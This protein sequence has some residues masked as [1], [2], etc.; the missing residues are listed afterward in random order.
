M[1]SFL[2]LLLF[3]VGCAALAVASCRRL[4]PETTGT[5]GLLARAVVGLSLVVVC[6]EAAGVL[7]G[8]VPWVLGAV[9]AALLLAAW[10]LDPGRPLPVVS[11]PDP[12]G[13]S[14]WVAVAA[15]AA[16]LIA[17]SGPIVESL[18][19]GIYRQDSLWYHLTLASGFVQ[20]GQIGGLQI[21]D[22][23]KLAAWFYPQNAE[24]FHGLGMLALGD[25][26]ASPFLNL[27][28]ASLTLLAGWCIGRRLG[29]PGTGIAATA[30]ILVTPMMLTQAGNAPN[31]AAG[32]ALVAAAI[33]M[34][35]AAN[36]DNSLSLIHI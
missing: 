5:T 32:L 22:P 27:L 1:I 3:L 34:L 23:L 16:V 20:D 15:C 11:R 17:W 14:V 33:A 21:T 30:L 24:I 29:R 10:R 13:S 31:D 26:F 12:S 4:A 18:D 35:L 8:F 2:F 25:D 19:G 28:W 9:G 6:S 36:G 7:G